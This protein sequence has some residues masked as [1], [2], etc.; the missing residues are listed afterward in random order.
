M[1]RT[2]AT[3]TA[4]TLLMAMPAAE[5]ANKQERAAKALR[6]A[7]YLML[8]ERDYAAAVKEYTK[9]LRL[10]RKN[11]KAQRALA[12]AYGKLG[13]WP[14]AVK[15]LAALAKLTPRDRSA[16]TELG[17]AQLRTGARD[18][19]LASFKKAIEIDRRYAPA[20]LAAA[21]I[22]YERYQLTKN[23]G[24]LK[25]ETIALFTQF[26]EATRNKKG[27]QAARAERIVAQLK[28]GKLAATIVDARRLYGQAFTTRRR[29][30]VMFE[31]AYSKLDEVLE[32][33]PGH[34]EALYYQGLI[35]LS[36]KSKRL[37]SIEKA[38]QKLAAAGDYAPALAELGR[39]ERK[40]DDLEAAST[41]L[42]KALQLDKT[43]QR[44]WYELGLVHK[45]SDKRD[46]AVEA[47]RKAV[48]ADPRSDV[49]A[50]AVVDLSHLAPQDTR[51]MRHYRSNKQFRA[52]IFD[53]EKFKGSIAM[54]ERRLG[55]VDE[56]AAEQAWLDEMMRRLLNATDQ[57]VSAVFTVKVVRTKMVN[58]FAVPNGN[59]YFT[60]GF[61]DFIKKSFP[62]LKMDAD[63]P[64]IAAVMGHEL[65]HVMK[66][67]VIRS[68]VFRDAMKQK[69]FN[70]QVMVSV[71]RN[72]EIEAD[73]EGMKLM[74]LAGYDPRWAVDLHAAYAK[75]LGEVPA[76][77]DHPTFDERVHYLE[78]Y[79]SNEMA[80][81]YASFKQGAT[82]LKEAAGVEAA[83]LNKAAALY[84]EAIDDLKR[85]TVA[86]KRTKEALNNLA[87]AHAKLGL[88]EQAKGGSKN[89]IAR[90][91]TEFSVEQDLALKF[92]PLARKRTT[93]GAAGGG[94]KTVLPASLRRARVLLERALKMDA[95]YARARLNLGVVR[96]ASG[97][98]AEARKAFEAIQTQCNEAKDCPIAADR[99]SNLLGIVKAEQGQMKSAV[100]D[101]ESSLEGKT[102]GKAPLRIF[103]LARALDK[104]D[105]KDDAARMYR[106]FLSSCGENDASTWAIQAR[107]ALAK[108][109]E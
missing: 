14:K 11:A 82:R 99:V 59:V 43:H 5:A 39:H 45:L 107:T 80:F 92:V 93:R 35:H 29:M 97:E 86:F 40:H 24:S 60:R 106:K 3:V 76:G 94:E 46:A 70:P 91:Y 19:A 90:W 4:V 98:F 13:K 20:L 7:N 79:W 42:L 83:D 102:E 28:G 17:K 75:A 71:T 105:R 73:R 63:N 50:R 12:G 36:V 85:F 2:V 77:L 57:K 34:Q 37:H 68:F 44:S 81:A 61:L 67:H 6:Y 65:T 55:G 74:F 32:K 66:E 87:L 30:H 78:E 25:T 96:L 100:A 21:A 103:N 8:V 72:H 52:D 49:A 51:V 9:V 1:L 101:F 56:R 108:L 84:K 54:L 69:R 64:A 41:Y 95:H 104:A 23:D 58:A 53:T 26:L 33:K 15:A 31:K 22:V 48:D 109:K 47:F 27:Y 18:K 38:V 62:D 10:D 89:A 88:F 16:W